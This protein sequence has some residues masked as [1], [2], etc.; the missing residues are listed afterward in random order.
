MNGH[1]V[2]LADDHQLVRQG[3]RALLETAGHTVVAEAADG[4]E[5]LALSREHS[6]EVLV[7]DISMPLLNGLDV[8]REL[9]RSAP[10]V[11]VVL[12]TMHTDRRY[13]T[14]A[15]KA[16]VRGYVHKSQAAEDLV[17]AIR[18]VVRG[19][20]YMSPT[21]MTTVVGA[22]LDRQ[23]ATL[24]PL[25]PREREVLQLV[26]EGK[27]TKVIARILGVSYKTAETHRS[28]IMR[29]LDIHETAGLVRYAIRR[30]MLQ[31]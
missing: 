10:R 26:A 8:A 17:R 25:T 28:H 22:Y 15:I 24:E 29:K 11:R 16:G 9:A 12:L 2:L 30:G 5:A 31:A 18:E 4:R 1:R 23:D 13:V 21:I 27:T 7:L 3:L 6:P 14:D 19:G 20:T